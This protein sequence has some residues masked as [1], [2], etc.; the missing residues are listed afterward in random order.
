MRSWFIQ[1]LWPRLQGLWLNPIFKTGVYLLVIIILISLIRMCGLS[2]DLTTQQTNTSYRGHTRP[3]QPSDPIP[4]SN[5]D[6]IGKGCNTPN[7]RQ[8]R[9]PDEIQ[10]PEILFDSDIPDG[11]DY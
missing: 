6:L 11:E 3:T 8:S 10:L 1:G 2:A 5:P 9:Q 4:T 7:C